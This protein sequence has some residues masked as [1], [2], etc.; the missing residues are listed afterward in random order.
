VWESVQLQASDQRL[1][2]AL[3]MGQ[4]SMLMWA[5]SKAPLPTGELMGTLATRAEVR[6]GA[7]A[8][9]RD[10]RVPCGPKGW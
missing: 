5:Y 10:K 2:D 6:A 3:N 9:A 4:I 1:E 8:L 7:L